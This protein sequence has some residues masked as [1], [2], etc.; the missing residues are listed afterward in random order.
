MTIH[1]CQ[2]SSNATHLPFLPVSFSLSTLFIYRRD[3][4]RCRPIFLTPWCSVIF[5]N[6]LT[7]CR[8]VE[9]HTVWGFF[10]FFFF[11]QF[12]LSFF[13]SPLLCLLLSPDRLHHAN[14]GDPDNKLSVMI[15]G[16]EGGGHKQKQTRTV[17]WA[18]VVQL[19]ARVVY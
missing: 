13:C 16:N 7:V 11:S 3:S 10:F 14:T 5:E 1:S 19:V 4:L 18:A 15:G 2:Q 17:V 12:S 6:V 8:C 9:L